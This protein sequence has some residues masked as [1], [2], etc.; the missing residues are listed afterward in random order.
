MGRSGFSVF[1]QAIKILL[2]HHND[3]PQSCI[4]LSIPAAGRNTTG[5]GITA[6]CTRHSI[7]TR[8]MVDTFSRCF[9][10]LNNA[11]SIRCTIGTNQD[12]TGTKIFIHDIA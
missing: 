8:G 12:I 1:A 11:L 6:R 7:L 4:L 9:I 2:T 5:T 10:S 3:K